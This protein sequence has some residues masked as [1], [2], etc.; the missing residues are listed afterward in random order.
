MGS[1]K[2]LTVMFIV[3]YHYIRQKILRRDMKKKAFTLI[4][5]LVVVVIIGILATLVTLAL[6]SATK[7]AKDTK[8]KSAIEQVQKSLLVA[9][10]SDGSIPSACVTSPAGW[11]EL[12][13]SGAGLTCKS[14]LGAFSSLPVDAN[15]IGIKIKVTDA[16]TPTYVVSGQ[17]TAYSGTNK[18]CWYVTESSNTGLTTGSGTTTVCP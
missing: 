14:A 2:L 17:G 6:S 1:G 3:G 12:S 9:I 13:N 7:K 11:I 16:S 10:N 15:N 18:Y 8:V 4:E 5:L